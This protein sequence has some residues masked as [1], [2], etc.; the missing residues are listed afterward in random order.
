MFVRVCNHIAFGVYATSHVRKQA[1]H[2]LS[3]PFPS[4]WAF[5]LSWTSL[6]DDR[7]RERMENNRVD[8]SGFPLICCS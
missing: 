6:G 2:R 7:K 8:V 1:G 3:F 4:I 5:V